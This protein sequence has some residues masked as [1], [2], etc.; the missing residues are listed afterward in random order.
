MVAG[1]EELKLSLTDETTPYIMGT[2]QAAGMQENHDKLSLLLS[3]NPVEDQLTVTC[4]SHT[5]GWSIL[6]FSGNTVMRGETTGSKVQINVSQLP[7]GVYFCRATTNQFCREVNA[8][9]VKNQFR[10]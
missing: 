2:I 3:P 4:P 10:K 5:F 6:D 9:F 8:K 1:F 7:A